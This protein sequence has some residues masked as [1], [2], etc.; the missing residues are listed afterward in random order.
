M[1]ES[2]ADAGQEQMQAAY[3]ERDVHEYKE[4]EYKWSVDYWHDT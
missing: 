4:Q 2:V 3:A 1:S